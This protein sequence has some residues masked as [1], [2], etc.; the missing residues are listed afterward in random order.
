MLFRPP[1]VSERISVDV[2]WVLANPSIF[3]RLSG[4]RWGLKIIIALF[5]ND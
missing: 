1:G 4:E 2:M 5:L 3:Q